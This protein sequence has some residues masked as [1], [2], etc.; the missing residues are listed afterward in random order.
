MGTDTGSTL[1]ATS[2]D[3]MTN[4]IGS[5]IGGAVER[6]DNCAEQNLGMNKIATNGMKS[7][8]ARVKVI[9]PL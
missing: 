2:P 4:S 1:N 5:R 3:P 7:H 8:N 6:P 9:A